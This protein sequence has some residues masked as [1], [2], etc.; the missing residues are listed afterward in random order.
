VAGS[1]TAPVERPARALSSPLRLGAPRRHV[2]GERRIRTGRLRL[3][4]AAS[5]T[6]AQQVWAGAVRFAHDGWAGFGQCAD[7]RG[8]PLAQPDGRSWLHECSFKEG[9][10]GHD[11]GERPMRVIVGTHIM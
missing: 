5:Y 7:L 11:A 3:D 10:V 1:I 2:Q 4:R 6:P 8:S 9:S